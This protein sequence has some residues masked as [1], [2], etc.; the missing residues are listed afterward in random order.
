MEASNR[1]STRRGRLIPRSKLRYLNCALSLLL[2]LGSVAFGQGVRG[3]IIGQVTDQTGAVIPGATATLVNVDTQQEVRT[4]KTDSSGVYQ[5]LE[6]E[7]AVYTVVL[8]AQGFSEARLQAI[9]LE[10]AR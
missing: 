7:P 5:F 1:W 8:K 4:V 3:T 6:L 2:I 9:K 10:P